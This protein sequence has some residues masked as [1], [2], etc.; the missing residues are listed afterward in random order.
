MRTRIALAFMLALARTRIP[1]AFVL[2]LA[3]A[4]GVLAQQPALYIVDP[5]W[6]KLPW[7]SNWSMQQ[8]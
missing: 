3:A 1:L 2:A 8:R 7:P 6:P 4:S 5:F